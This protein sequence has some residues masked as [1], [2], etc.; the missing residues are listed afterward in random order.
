MPFGKICA[1]CG[2]YTEAPEGGR[3][4]SCAP[5]FRVRD[6]RR[7]Q[8]RTKRDGRNRAEYRDVVRPAVLARDRHCVD[9][10]S[11][12]N[13]EAHLVAGGWHGSHLSA[14]ETLC[15]SCHGGRPPARPRPL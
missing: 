8:A 3:C 4:E 5:P 15:A 7:R 2:R 6:A 10:G 1:D 14:Y 9:C 13:L 11:T 12:K